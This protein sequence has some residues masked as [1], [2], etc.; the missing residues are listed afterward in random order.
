MAKIEQQILSN[1]AQLNRASLLRIMGVIVE[2][3][4]E[5]E[6]DEYGLSPAQWNRTEEAAANYENGVLPTL[7]RKEL[8]AKIESLQDEKNDVPVRG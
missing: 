3:L 1:I 7:S 2:K 4:Q 5:Q 8:E 6:P